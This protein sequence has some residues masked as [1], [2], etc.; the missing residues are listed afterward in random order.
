[1]NIKNWFNKQIE[2]EK[3]KA[4]PVLSFPS[5]SLL[6]ITAKDLVTD[7]DNQAKGMKAVADK[8][9]SAASVSMMDLSVEAEAFGSEIRLYD[10]EVPA[11]IGSIVR[12]QEEADSL[13]VPEVGA[14][15]TGNYINAITKACQQITDRPVFAGTIGPFSLAGRLM[16]VSEIMI[17]CYDDPDMVHTVVSKCTDFLIEYLNAYKSTGCAGVVVAEP[18]T[19]LLSADLAQEFSTDYIKKIVSSVQ[20]DQ[21]AIIY[22]NCG[23]SVAKMIPSLI[24]A[25]CMAYHFGNAVKMSEILPQFPANIPVMGN[26]D[27]AGQFCNGTEE[28]IYKATTELLEECSSYKNFIIS[29]GCDIPPKTPWKNIES[30]FKAVNDFYSK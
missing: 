8:V 21:F 14:G 5:V 10:E 3:K 7:S 20:T 22:H 4:F 9:N 13:E 12:T 2:S 27:P 19:G 26:I 11:V 17:D 18:L 1:M 30:F 15:R 29:S 23:P 16:D 6:G 25:G 28:S 24:D